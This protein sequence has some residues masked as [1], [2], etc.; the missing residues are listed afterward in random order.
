MQGLYMI[1]ENIS[2]WSVIMDMVRTESPKLPCSD[3]FIVF[4]QK[5]WHHLCIGS[6]EFT[7]ILVIIHWRQENLQK[8]KTSWVAISLSD[9]VWLD[10]KSCNIRNVSF[11]SR[12]VS[13]TGSTNTQY[14]KNV[15]YQDDLV[16]TVHCFDLVSSVHWRS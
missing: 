9:K 5:W 15:L 13:S 16:T 1:E 8:K 7:K 10:S 14:Y 6:L 12:L 3:M 11:I 4:I 2:Y